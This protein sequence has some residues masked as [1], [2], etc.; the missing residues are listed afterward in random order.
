[1]EFALR[2]S[3]RADVPRGLRV[4]AGML[5][6]AVRPSPCRFARHRTEYANSPLKLWPWFDRR[7][8]GAGLGGCNEQGF[9]SRRKPLRQ[10]ARNTCIR[11][12]A[13]RNHARWISY[14][15]ARYIAGF[16]GQVFLGLTDKSGRKLRADES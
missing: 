12:A 16:L 3:A 10:H 15:R 9:R 6:S 7:G 1:M 5:A 14:F 11:H 13:P 8:N 2:A 4:R